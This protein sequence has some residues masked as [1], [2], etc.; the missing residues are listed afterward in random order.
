[1]RGITISYTIVSLADILI[2]RRDFVPLEINSVIK[3]KI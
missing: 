1:V 3:H 2:V